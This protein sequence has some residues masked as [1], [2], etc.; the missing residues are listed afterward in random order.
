MSDLQPCCFLA[1]FGSFALEC[2]LLFLR[3]NLVFDGSYKL[4]WKL[5]K[6]EQLN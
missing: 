4:S 5:C 2:G 3:H 6:T 1:G